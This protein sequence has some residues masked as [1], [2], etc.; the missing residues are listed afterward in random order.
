M[1]KV[2][3]RIIYNQISL[4]FKDIFSKFL[5]GFRKDFSTQ[6]NLIRLLQKWQKC[7]D[8]KGVVGTIL[9]DLSKAYENA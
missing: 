7:L 6:H 1:S 8:E 3:E 5:C 2:F 4:I 9:I